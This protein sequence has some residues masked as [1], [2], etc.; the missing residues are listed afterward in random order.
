MSSLNIVRQLI[1]DAIWN[2]KNISENT[3][4]KACDR[5][6]I[7]YTSLETTRVFITM[8]RLV[9]VLMEDLANAIQ[10]EAI[11]CVDDHQATLALV[12]KGVICSD[13]IPEPTD[14]KK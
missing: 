14:D 10:A 6:D 9:V 11:L 4:M 12:A 2:N 5:I 7:R 1:S 8:R 3:K 13:L